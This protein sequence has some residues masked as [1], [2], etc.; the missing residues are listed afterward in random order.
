MHSSIAHARPMV[1]DRLLTQIALIHQS[2]AS[3]RLYVDVIMGSLRYLDMA[4]LSSN[5]VELLADE[6]CSRQIPPV[7]MYGVV[8]FHV[9]F[10]VF[11]SPVILISKERPK[12]FPNLMLRTN[13]LLSSTDRLSF[14]LTALQP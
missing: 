12:L 10:P 9:A 13:S 4:V 7:N 11:D 8:T 5:G 14:V 6:G 1:C 3:I 2:A